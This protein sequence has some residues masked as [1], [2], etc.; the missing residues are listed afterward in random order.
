MLVQL[1]RISTIKQTS[2]DSVQALRSCLVFDQEFS[3]QLVINEA[4]SIEHLIRIY[5]QLAIGNF[6]LLIV[7][8]QFVICICYWQFLIRNQKTEIGIGNSNVL[9]QIN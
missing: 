4:K 5:W 3:Q 2:T 7:D 8:C 9:W 1:I 6:Q